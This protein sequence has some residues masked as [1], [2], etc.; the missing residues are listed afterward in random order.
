MF[1]SVPFYDIVNWLGVG[2]PSKRVFTLGRRS[3]IDASSPNSCTIHIVGRNGGQADIDQT[4]WDYVCD[5][6]NQ[7][8]PSRRHITTNY[9][10][11]RGFRFAPS[12]PALCRAYCEE[13]GIIK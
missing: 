13:K 11:L 12:V 8:E 9:N 7:T 2:Q 4:Y 10:Q 1:N 3:Y 6:I 5:V